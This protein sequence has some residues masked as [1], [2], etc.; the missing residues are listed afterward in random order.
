MSKKSAL[1]IKHST[2]WSGDRC[3]A[4]FD[5][6]GYRLEWCFPA[7]GQQLPDPRSFD[8]AVVFGGR[9]SVND[10]EAWIKAEHQWLESC[11]KTEC[12]F[13]GIC[14][15]GQLLA[16]VLGASVSKHPKGLKEVG[17][18]EIRPVPAA[19]ELLPSPMCLFQWHGDGF[20]IPAS[21][22][23]L[24]TGDR[25]PNQ[26]FRYGDRAIGVQFHPEVNH[27]VATQWFGQNEDFESEFL[28]PASRKGHLQQALD[29][30]AQ[31]DHWFGKFMTNW[32]HSTQ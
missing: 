5:D 9:N 20:D 30:D 1:L 29:T 7:D 32:L 19:N 2:T 23:R 24:G 10:N 6:M 26:A 13:L 22:T 8:A 28:D 16:K 15:G 14:F 11:L 31:I 27:T 17:F 25:F 21:A 18:H 3:S 12:R 4:W